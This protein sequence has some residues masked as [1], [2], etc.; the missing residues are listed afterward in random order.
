VSCR[1]FAINEDENLEVM[2]RD[3]KCLEGRRQ[4]DRKSQLESRVSEERATSARFGLG[5][6]FC[7]TYCS[8]TDCNEM[9]VDF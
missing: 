8:T 2:C 7:D 1:G 5:L 4:A 3:C 6:G 9:H